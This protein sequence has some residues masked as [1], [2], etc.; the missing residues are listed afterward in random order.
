VVRAAKYIWLLT[1][2]S[3]VSSTLGCSVQES[4]GS[5]LS[6]NTTDFGVED[7]VCRDDYSESFTFTLYGKGYH[8]T[9][10]LS[11]GCSTDENFGAV[12]ETNGYK[13]SYER[14][15]ASNT[16]HRIGDDTYGQCGV[17]TVPQ[18]RDG[19][20]HSTYLTGWCTAHMQANCCCYATVWLSCLSVTPLR[21]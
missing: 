20:V 6:G 10:S 12:L 8:K 14:G 18:G 16:T 21:L 3:W 15:V 1:V 5:N 4:T 11:V 17:S 9:N 13:C 19:H 2:L 7:A